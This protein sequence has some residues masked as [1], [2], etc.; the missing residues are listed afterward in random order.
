MH[1]IADNHT[2]RLICCEME[3]SD[4]V[5]LLPLGAK[6]SVWNHFGFPSKEVKIIE[7]NKKK[8]KRVFHKLCPSNFA[9]TGNTTNMWNHLE[10]A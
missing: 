10:E 1:T 5:Q 2:W 3:L 8:K 4:N 7:A 9:Y 6:S